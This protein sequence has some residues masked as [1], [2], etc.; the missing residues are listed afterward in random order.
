MS[1]RFAL[2]YLLPT[3]SPQRLYPQPAIFC[4]GSRPLTLTWTADRLDEIVRRIVFRISISTNDFGSNEQTYAGVRLGLT[5]ITNFSQLKD[6]Y[7]IVLG[8]CQP[9]YFYNKINDL[10]GIRVPSQDEYRTYIRG[11]SKIRS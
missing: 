4:I 5:S 8:L 11:H 9:F 2:S 3:R 10:R 6:H 1:S 7:R